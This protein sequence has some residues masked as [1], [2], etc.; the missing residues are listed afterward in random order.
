MKKKAFFEMVSSKPCV[1][2]LRL[3]EDAFC[4]TKIQIS[5][6]EVIREFKHDVKP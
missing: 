5:P 6:P 2:F 4:V 3:E 1:I